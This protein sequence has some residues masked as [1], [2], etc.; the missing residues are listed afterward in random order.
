MLGWI[1]VIADDQLL[2]KIGALV[3][4][5]LRLIG[6]AYGAIVASRAAATD[7][8]TSAPA[9]HQNG[10]QEDISEEE[11]N[12]RAYTLVVLLNLCHRDVSLLQDNLDQLLDKIDAVLRCVLSNL[13]QETQTKSNAAAVDAAQRYIELDALEI[14]EILR[15]SVTLLSVLVDQVDAVVGKLL[16]RKML[17]QLLKLG[18]FL[19]GDQSDLFESQEALD[20]AKL[21]VQIMIDAV[22]AHR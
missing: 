4:S 19:S 18:R 17:P 8:N 9:T 14:P 6:R 12:I 7:D 15:M 11:C 5:I 13:L 3:P 20:D 1:A 2:P 22:I 16:D 21:R 10:R